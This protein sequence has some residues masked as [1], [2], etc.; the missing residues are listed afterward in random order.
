VI[1]YIGW[2]DVVLNEERAIN[3]LGFCNMRESKRD[4]WLATI[5]ICLNHFPIFCDGMFC[6]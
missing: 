5:T 6:E 4:I 2:V 1:E 3:D